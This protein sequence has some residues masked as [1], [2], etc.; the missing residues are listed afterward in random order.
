LDRTIN[1]I[2]HYSYVSGPRVFSTCPMN[3]Q[4]S[5]TWFTKLWNFSLVPYIISAVKQGSRQR[6]NAM[7]WI[8][9]LDWV[10]ER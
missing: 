3:N 5:L 1:T 7:E 6:N 10:K 2:S 8:D 4:Q 9:P